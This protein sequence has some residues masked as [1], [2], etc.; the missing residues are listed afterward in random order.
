MTMV[1]TVD[2]R[3]RFLAGPHVAVLS[4]ADGDGRG[5]LSMPVWYLYEPGGEIL[6]STARDS[7]KM[8]LIR[9]AGRVSLIVQN[10]TPPY[11]SYASVEGP[12]T[13]IEAATLEQGKA[14]AKR[15]LSP[16]HAALYLESTKDSTE[17]FDVVRVRPERWFT[18]D[19]AKR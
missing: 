19:Y 3:E 5:P 14:L 12:V 17:I 2:E 8:D 10:A 16:E 4:V 7:R 18:R 6:F 15:Y 9:R 1:M 11:Y 13:A